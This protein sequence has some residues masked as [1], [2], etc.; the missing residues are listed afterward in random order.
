MFIIVR[1]KKKKRDIVVR[2]RIS[3]SPLSFLEVRGGG[4][5]R[6]FNGESFEETKLKIVPFVVP[7][8]PR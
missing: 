1:N 4:T 7:D 8:V 5:L 2:R 3:S 6:R